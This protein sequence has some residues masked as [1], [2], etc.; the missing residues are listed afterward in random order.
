MKNFPRAWKWC[1]KTNDLNTPEPK[2]SPA[3]TGILLADQVDVPRASL[4]HSRLSISVLVVLL[5]YPLTI[6]VGLGLTAIFLWCTILHYQVAISGLDVTS[7]VLRCWQ[8]QSLLLM[9]L[10]CHL[11]RLCRMLVAPLLFSSR[12][13]Q[14]NDR[15]Y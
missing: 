13:I 1:A 14:F 10:Q 4:A 11:W 2:H 15:H 8:T 9:M 6:V 5:K 3:M 12:R 7:S